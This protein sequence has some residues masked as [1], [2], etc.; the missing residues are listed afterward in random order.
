MPR[1]LA[2]F[3]LLGC[4]GVVP[5]HAQEGEKLLFS[6]PK[7][8]GPWKTITNQST[9]KLTFIERIPESQD[10]ASIQDMIVE[11]WFSGLPLNATPTNVLAL[12][13]NG[14]APASCEQIR[15]YGPFADTQY[16]SPTARARYFCAKVKDKPYGLVSIIKAVRG[17]DR[18]YVIQREWRL[19]PYDLDTLNRLTGLIPRQAFSSETDAL[20]W[21]EAYASTETW[22]AESVFVCDSR[23]ATKP[24]PK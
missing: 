23:D 20:K 9:D 11:Q 14:A 1:W 10:A 24:C 19:P 7:T 16:G 17:K 18:L 2:S 15:A 5:C 3:A 8:W 21:Y 12:M 6:V 13:I 4:L 22:L